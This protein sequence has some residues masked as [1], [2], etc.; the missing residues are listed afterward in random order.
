MEHPDIKHVF[1]Y[2]L[3]KKRQHAN[4]TQAALAAKAK[5]SSN[6]I[7]LIENGTKF[8]SAPMIERLAQALELPATRLFEPVADSELKSSRA[9]VSAAANP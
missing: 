3:R 8:P 5:T 4:L 2:N 1:G 9:R 7:A 6:Y